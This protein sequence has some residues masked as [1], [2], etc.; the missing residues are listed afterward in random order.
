[1]TEKEVKELEQKANTAVNVAV[2]ATAATGAIPIPVAD[3]PIMIGEQVALMTSICDIY[4]IKL[5]KEGLKMLVVAALSTGGAAFI[6]KTVATS[7]LKLLPGAGS[8]AGGA[9][10][11]TTAGVVT[12]AMGHAFIDVCN[13]VKLGKLSESDLT[14][15]EGIEAF[16]QAYR[17][18]FAEREKSIDNAIDNSEIK[19]DV[20]K[21]CLVK[22]YGSIPV[23]IIEQYRGEEGAPN[24]DEYDFDKIFKQVEKDYT[25][26]EIYNITLYIKK[27]EGKIYY[28]INGSDPGSISL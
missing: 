2:A 14:H 27:E 11:A 15:S 3:M 24:E 4:G 9:I 20:K 1:M 18:E 23:E 7:L 25:G 10:S 5:K 28:I 19:E 21:G 16:K 22:T 6:G 12:Y 17:R 26:D 8:I 13:M